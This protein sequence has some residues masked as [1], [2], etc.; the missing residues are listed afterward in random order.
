MGGWK[1]NWKGSSQ[2]SRCQNSSSGPACCALPLPQSPCSW[3]QS[4][5]AGKYVKIFLYTFLSIQ[6]PTIDP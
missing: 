5:R 6:G 2:A 3:V 4:K 1:Q